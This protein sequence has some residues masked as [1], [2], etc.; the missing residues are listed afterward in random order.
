MNVLII[1]FI[2]AFSV[3]MLLILVSQSAWGQTRFRWM[4]SIIFY[5]FIGALL[6]MSLMGA[7]VFFSEK[8][9]PMLTNGG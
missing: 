6:G 8:M 9:Q 5:L 1:L 4:T 3:S 2:I 7:A